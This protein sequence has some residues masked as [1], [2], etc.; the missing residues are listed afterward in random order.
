MEKAKKLYENLVENVNSVYTE[1]KKEETN[2]IPL[3]SFI[4]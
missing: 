3:P 1:T 2:E 4:L